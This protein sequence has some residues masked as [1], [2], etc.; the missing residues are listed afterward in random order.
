[1]NSSRTIKQSLKSAMTKHRKDSTVKPLLKF[2]RGL[3]RKGDRVS[4]HLKRA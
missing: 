3:G 2:S 1:M 4:N